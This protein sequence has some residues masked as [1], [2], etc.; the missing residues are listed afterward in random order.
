MVTVVTILLRV[1]V[2]SF[3][4]SP[5][6]RPSRKAEMKRAIQPYIPFCSRADN[7]GADRWSKRARKPRDVPAVCF[8]RD[9]RLRGA[10]GD[11]LC[12]ADDRVLADKYMEPYHDKKCVRECAFRLDDSAVV[13]AGLDERC[14]EF[15]AV[16]FDL[17]YPGADI[18]RAAFLRRNSVQ[19]RRSACVDSGD[20]SH[21][22][23][24][25][26]KG[27]AE[28]SGSRRMTA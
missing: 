17:F 14:T 10:V 7:R 27:S 1:G 22:R 9:S 23:F 8:K 11:K 15:H 12:S 6:S 19:V 28:I 21:W 5:S 25:L 3:L 2:V 13:Y 4:S 20:L 26:E 16:F 24:S 18:S